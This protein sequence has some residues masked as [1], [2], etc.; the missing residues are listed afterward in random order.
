[1]KKVLLSALIASATILPCIVHAQW[2]VY[3]S[4]TSSWYKD[5]PAFVNNTWT[6]ATQSGHGG[7]AVQEGSTSYPVKGG[8][9]QECGISGTTRISLGWVGDPADVPQYVD[10]RLT[11]NTNGWF[12]TAYSGTSYFSNTLFHQQMWT[13]GDSSQSGNAFTSN[14]S[15][16]IINWWALT[17]PPPSKILYRADIISP[18]T[19]PQLVAHSKLFW[20]SPPDPSGD[21]GIDVGAGWYVSVQPLAYP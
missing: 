19:V 18:V 10:L 21:L 11:V 17:G 14:T 2:Q 13:N 15:D 5:F 3:Y 7:T 6:E 20:E 1:M 8:F 9:F 12:D 4:T 16:Y